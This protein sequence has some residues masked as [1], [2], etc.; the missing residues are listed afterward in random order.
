MNYKTILGERIK[1]LRKVRRLTQGSLAERV[2]RSKNH[3]SK[4]E[5]GT[6]NPPLSLLLEIAFALE[7]T[8]SELL[9]DTQ[10]TLSEHIGINLNQELLKIKN[11][12]N[13]QIILDTIKILIEKYS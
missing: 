9:G 4:I 3:I 10:K 8:P 6:A 5:Q 1:N 13:R 11:I 7:I 2:N 12:K